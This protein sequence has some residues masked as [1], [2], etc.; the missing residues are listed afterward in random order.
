MLDSVRIPL[1]VLNA[2]QL[3]AIAA[4]AFALAWVGLGVSAARQA[5]VDAERTVLAASRAFAEALDHGL[6]GVES[7]A[8]NAGLLIRPGDPAL[9]DAER[10]MLLQDWL[11]LN[12][13][14]REALQ[15]APDGTV[16]AAS[17]ARRIGAN[18][19]RQTWFAKA[20]NAQ[21]IVATG[22]EEAS[23]LVEMAVSLGAPGPSDRLLLR[24]GADF[25]SGIEARL[26]RSL[27]LPESVAF[28]VTGADG[29]VLAGAPSAGTLAPVTASTPMRGDRDLASPGWMVTAQSARPSA[30]PI[31][32]PSGGALSLGL[33]LV[34]CAAGLGYA[35][36][37]RAAR[38]LIRLAEPPEQEGEAA[39]GSRVRE[40]DALTRSVLG[41]ARRSETVLAGA[42][43]GLDRVKRRLQTFEAMSGWSCWEIDPETRRVIWSDQDTIGTPAAVDRT[44]ELADL[45]DRF[46]PADH[47]LLTLTLQAALQA[48]GP[49]DVV[50]RTRLPGPSGSRR[51][52]VRFL[53]DGKPAEGGAPRLHALSRALPEAGA[54]EM[55]PTA[56]ANERR[57]DLV[58]RR[59]TDGIVHDFND[60]LTIV[61]TNLGA[62]RRRHPLDAEPARLVDAALTGA[63]RGTA[64]TRRMLHLVRGD[65]PS[66]AE[67][68]LAAT[69]SAFLPFLQS[70][71]LRGTPVIDR[72]PG[73]LPR[74]R[75]SDRLLEVMLL[76]VAFHFRDLGLN[77]FAIG[78][79]EHAAGDETGLD[80]PA[81]AYLRLLLASGRP[82]PGVAPRATPTGALETVAL[83][84]A[85]IGGGLHLLS[86]GSGDAAFLA[87]I[88]LPAAGRPAEAEPDSAGSSW[89]SRLRI[90]LV[91]SDSLVRA[92]V[93]EALVDLGHSVVQAASGEHALA[94]LGESAAY[95][96][97][98]A[99]QAMPVMT[100]LQLAATVVERHPN[101][102][103]ILASPHG[104]LPAAARAFLQLDKPFRQEDLAAILGAVAPHQAQAA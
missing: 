52:L 3:A 13:I 68:D 6:R 32:V 95:D 99:D 67:S 26:R 44:A 5:G 90:L 17:E 55:P 4:I 70:N 27:A 37:G 58:L 35:L 74:A 65:S 24:V 11:A 81:G 29:R 100:G 61:Q 72:I 42:G 88:W 10:S 41:R 12:T 22:G 19:S 18:L 51:V 85:E 93:A 34:L 64:L 87:E 86:D 73:D 49:H 43:T 98:I 103:I 77:G 47:A 25:F 97:M 83:L 7:D 80:L 1:K 20:R 59:V 91:E 60:A 53:R 101:I 76:N 50:L 40:F 15:V 96:A 45:T 23:G 8:R 94:M 84:L 66:L 36:A 21:V 33:A 46:D 39:P 14:Y 69:V 78:A 104:Q 62:L 31:G 30:A 56:S 38:P 28:V 92:S 57:R 102:R 16:R 79:A 75:C 9:P 2:A 82:T 71:V 89:Q 63:I 48:D 54:G